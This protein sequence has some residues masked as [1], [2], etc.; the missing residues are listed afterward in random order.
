M[1][2]GAMDCGVRAFE[3]ESGEVL[4]VYKCCRG[5]CGLFQRCYAGIAGRVKET[6][7]DTLGPHL[8]WSASEDGSCRQFDFR[9]EHKCTVSLVDCLW[10]NVIL[11]FV[12]DAAGGSLQERVV[13]QPHVNEKCVVVV[14]PCC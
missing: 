11:S 13:S 10:L 3:I 12:F 1:V 9:Q 2:S 14:A 8:F 7:A 4:G 5:S 6:V